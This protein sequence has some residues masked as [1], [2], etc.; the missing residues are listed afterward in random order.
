MRSI[1]GAEE[2]GE[3][4]EERVA[5]LVARA[6]LRRAARRAF[7][8]LMAERRAHG[9][10]ARYAAKPPPDGDDPDDRT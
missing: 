7:R 9:L 10:R 6:A 4:A 3:T 8:A 1:P 5:A 2:P